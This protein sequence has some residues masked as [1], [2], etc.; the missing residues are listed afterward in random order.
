MCE[1]NA[2]QCCCKAVGSGE[3][4][5][6]V[7]ELSERHSSRVSIRENLGRFCC[8]VVIVGSQQRLE[9]VSHVLVIVIKYHIR[10]RQN[11]T[12]RVKAYPEQCCLV[13]NH[14]LAAHVRFTTLISNTNHYSNGTLVKHF[15]IFDI[16]EWSLW[17]IPFWS[18]SHFP[19]SSCSI[20]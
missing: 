12:I 13:W 2:V 6:N 5:L 18:C 15:A 20:W 4:P 1:R 9:E 16:F 17:M 7:R 3:S 10:D 14:K 11:S 19:T 8:F